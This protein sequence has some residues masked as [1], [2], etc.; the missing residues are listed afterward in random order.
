MTTLFCHCIIHTHRMFLKLHAFHSWQLIGFCLVIIYIIYGSFSSDFLHCFRKL[1]IECECGGGG[2]G[3]RYEWNF[4]NLRI[5]ICRYFMACLQRNTKP[6]Q[7]HK[8]SF[9]LVC[10]T[11][12]NVEIFN[13]KLIAWE[14]KNWKK[15]KLIYW[16]N[17]SLQNIF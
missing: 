15:I 14:E 10:L 7:K 6:S 17:V 13:W 8:F 4:W 2:D 3:G 11:G 1:I 9:L 12:F 5:N 16:L